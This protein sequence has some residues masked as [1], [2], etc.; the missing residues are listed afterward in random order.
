[1]SLIG[2]RTY[3]YAIF[4]ATLVRL[5]TAGALGGREFGEHSRRSRVCRVRSYRRKE[6]RGGI[7]HP[8]TLL[9]LLCDQEHF[10]SSYLHLPPY[11]ATRTHTFTNTQ[12]TIVATQ[13]AYTKVLT[14]K[15]GTVTL[16]TT[17]TTH[18]PTTTT[19]TTTGMWIVDLVIRGAQ[20]LG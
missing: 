15:R 2:L 19:S 9:E 8:P 5:V 18:V 7:R 17:A 4:F 10:C 14:D 20:T 3:I 16:T 6:K 12:Y 11:A 13:T 1:M